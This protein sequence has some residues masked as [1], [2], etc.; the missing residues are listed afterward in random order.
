MMSSPTAPPLE[1]YL[2][3]MVEFA[4][5][6]ML[7]RRLVYEQGERG[8]GS[9]VLCEHP[10]TISVGRSGS[11]THI[12]PDDDELRALGIKVQWVNRGGGCVLHLPG[13][14]AAY[15]A[16]PL[17]PLGRNLC[18]YLDGLHDAVLGVLEEFD[19]QGEPGGPTCPACFWA[20]RGWRRSAWRST[21]GSLITGSP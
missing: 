16:L 6:Q 3:G 10:P 12:V 5:A 2:L 11:R 4:D 7:Q 19:L 9:L 17:E 21:A 14:L 13:Q 1:I 20:R 8:G 18:R 15:L